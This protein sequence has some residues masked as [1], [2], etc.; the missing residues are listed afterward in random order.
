MY[1]PSMIDRIERAAPVAPA[2][3]LL[4]TYTCEC[5]PG[6]RTLSRL[7]PT[8]SDR[9]SS[10]MLPQP[11]G[12]DRDSLL[13][14]AMKLR[15]IGLAPVPHLAAREFSDLDDLGSFLAKLVDVG[16]VREVVVVGGD[17]SEPVGKF[18][19]AMDL[20]KTG[21]FEAHGITRIGVAGYPEDHPFIPDDIL[22][23]R[24]YQKQR[25]AAYSGVEMYVL[26]QICFDPRRIVNWLRYLR[27]IGINLP[28][29]VGLAGAMPLAR[30]IELAGR[31]GAGGSVRHLFAD[32]HHA[33]A[34][35]IY[36]PQREVIELATEWMN[37]G[38]LNLQGVHFYPFGFLSRTLNWIES[39]HRGSR[40]S[41]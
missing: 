16:G 8:A 25:W 21:L 10:V 1:S 30:I 37:D 15:D 6:D 22:L 18:S 38:T 33:T 36:F 20:L 26:S 31:C 5:F 39:V 13:Q 32:N 19:G 7:S 29:R 35:Q 28:V 12:R 41:S 14:L 9:I 24:L 3:R 4:E 40:K 11:P 2:V 34:G 17:R 27:E 23:D